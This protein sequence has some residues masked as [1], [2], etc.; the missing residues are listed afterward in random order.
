MLS[1]TGLNA[2]MLPLIVGTP[3]APAENAIVPASEPTAEADTIEEA[4]VIETE[5]EQKETSK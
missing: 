5:E 2:E 1:T 4:E 3:E